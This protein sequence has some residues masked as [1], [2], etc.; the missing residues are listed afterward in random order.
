MPKTEV[1]SEEDDNTLG[2]GILRRTF[3]MGVYFCE[4]V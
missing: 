3:R 4:S 2:G 1:E